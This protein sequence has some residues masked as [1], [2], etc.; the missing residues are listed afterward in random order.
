MSSGLFDKI[1]Q[2]RRLLELNEEVSIEEIK[3]AYRGLVQKYHPDKC[4]EEKKK[5]CEKKFREITQAKDELIKYCMQYKISFKEND[6]NERNLDLDIMQGY[7]KRFY[8]SWMF[9]V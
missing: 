2:S 9:D 1:D 6:V 8:D 7:Q 3:T 4:S 5:F